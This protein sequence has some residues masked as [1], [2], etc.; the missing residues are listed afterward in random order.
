MQ[1]YDPPLVTARHASCAVVPNLNVYSHIK[2]PNLIGQNSSDSPIGSVCHELVKIVKKNNEEHQ[3]LKNTISFKFHLQNASSSYRQKIT[4]TE[5]D[6][7]IKHW[8]KTIKCIKLPT[9]KSVEE[10]SQVPW[11]IKINWVT[12]EKRFITS[13][14]TELSFWLQRDKTQKFTVLLIYFFLI[15]HFCFKIRKILI[16]TRLKKISSKS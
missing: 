7:K 3:S 5:H 1:K 6:F 2:K 14:P 4:T 15:L 9:K 13:T 10:C 8:S 12:C 16:E 11:V